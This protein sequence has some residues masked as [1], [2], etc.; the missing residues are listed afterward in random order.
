M[1][2]LRSDGCV[3]IAPDSVLRSLLTMTAPSMI[4]VVLALVSVIVA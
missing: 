4:L 3:G 2:G 1:D